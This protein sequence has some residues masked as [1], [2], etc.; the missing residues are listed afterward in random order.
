[1]YYCNMLQLEK[2]IEVIFRMSIT[3]KLYGQVYWL[4]IDP[5]ICNLLYL[6]YVNVNCCSVLDHDEFCDC[7]ADYDYLAGK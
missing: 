3:A 1:M 5:H 4:K 6:T 7:G 2:Y